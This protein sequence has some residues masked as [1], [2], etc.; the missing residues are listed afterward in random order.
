MVYFQKMGEKKLKKILCSIL[1][2]ILTSTLANANDTQ[3]NINLREMFQNNES[4]IYAINLRTFNANDKNGNGIIDFELGENSGS[5]IN[6]IDRLDEIKDLGINTIHL[7]PITPVGKIKALGTAGSLYAMSDLVGLNLQLLDDTSEL[8]LKDQAKKFV[9][10]CHK[11]NIKVIVDLPSCG[12]YDYFINRPDLFLTD[13]GGEPIIPA[14]WTDVRLFNVPNN[15]SLFKSDIFILHKIFVDYMISLGVDGI[16][17]DVATIKPYIFWKELISYTRSKKSDFLFLAEASENWIQPASNHAYFTDWKRL[18]EAGFD[19]Y[20]GNYFDLSN[21]Q[22]M[23]KLSNSVLTR[24]KL[25]NKFHE[26]KSVIGSFETHDVVSPLLVGGENYSKIII[27]LNST[28]PLNP[29]Y[30]DGFLQG[31]DYLYEYSN[32]KAGTTYTDDD[33]YYVHKGQIDIF[34]FSRKPVGESEILINEQKQAINLRN[35]FNEQI[36]KGLFIPLETDNNKIFAYQ[37]KYNN[38]SVNIVINR[39]L[40]NAENVN[41]KIKN[42]TKKSQVN[43]VKK[44]NDIELKKSIMTI[45]M[46]AA[47]VV[48]FT[49]DNKKKS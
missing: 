38:K 25:L 19:G 16:R 27:W 15:Q 49:I 43:F 37:R 7:L 28:L 46:K 13:E 34:N 41:V 18:L 10:E 33:Y 30:V 26:K 8:S 6:A 47:S 40:A 23:D 22:T 9:Q 45:K 21:W 44:Q 20:Y 5:F 29:Y 1:L 35:E 17:A 14:D 11:R 39:N 12:S 3:K 32:K 31:D 42:L 2:M 48:V 36:T 24:R 4:I